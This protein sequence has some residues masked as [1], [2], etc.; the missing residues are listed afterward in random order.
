[1]AS[2]TGW[3]DPVRRR[4]TIAI[5]TVAVGAVVLAGV[6]T[7]MSSWRH[8]RAVAMSQLRDEA[9]AIVPFLAG[10][11]DAADAEPLSAKRT[12]NRVRALRRALRLV[13]ASV[14]VV[15]RTGRITSG[16]VP[17]GVTSDQ[18]ATVAI[19]G[20]TAS[21]MSRRLAWA[22]G[23][24]LPDE[25]GRRFVVI[26]T[27]QVPL[28]PSAAVWVVLSGL[29]AVVVA[30]IAGDLV[31]RRLAS[32]IQRVE[33]AT[34]RIADGD[35][36]A[37]VGEV[38]PDVGAETVRLAQ[39]VDAMASSLESA[40]GN[41]RDFL[42]SVS[43]DLRTPL[44]SM[45]GYA[46]AIVDGAAPDTVAAAQVIVAQSARLERLVADLLD[47]GR[48]QADQF[49]LAH[50]PIDI[51]GLAHASVEGIIPTATAWGIAL[52][53][54][55]EVPRAIFDGD[56]DRVAQVLANLIENALKF[57]A[58]SVHVQVSIVDDEVRTSVSDDGPGIR[59]EDLPRVF[60]RLF[61]SRPTQSQEAGRQTGS[62]LGLAICRELTESMGGS[63]DVAC[64]PEAGG[65]TFTVTFGPIV[66]GT[67]Q[68][69][70][71]IGASD[72]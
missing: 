57:A 51:V 53:F 15:D 19:D 10:T 61:V 18:V 71:P 72:H 39:S 44:T 58:T 46:E 45:R 30:G 26:L 17:D 60:D 62:G 48:I 3:V 11:I 40:R 14:V 59:P 28:V 20:G 64:G 22:A 63:V 7:T 12:A 21:G 38:P 47:L 2:V 56:A 34:R 69:D 1:M 66:D 5:V 49:S 8:T 29:A 54:G 32:P 36:S 50:E 23:A 41:Q 37:R 55:A 31:A 43:H 13:D 35:L 6:G 68:E 16:M 42:L 4:I 67:R 27:R 9:A 24:S 33:Q 52:D 70:A 65:T 25:A